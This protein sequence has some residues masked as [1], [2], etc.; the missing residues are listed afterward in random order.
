MKTKQFKVEKPIPSWALR[1]IRAITKLVSEEAIV[2]LMFHIGLDEV[3]E[4]FK[5][6]VTYI[7]GARKKRTKLDEQTVEVAEPA[8]EVAGESPHGI[9]D[10]DFEPYERGEEG[11]NNEPDLAVVR[12]GPGSEISEIDEFPDLARVEDGEQLMPD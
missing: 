2:E 10:S 11:I 6:I 4:L 9:T 3:E 1:R 8:Q 5:P 7:Q 12:P